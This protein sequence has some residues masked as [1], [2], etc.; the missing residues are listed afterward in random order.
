MKVSTTDFKNAV[1]MFEAKLIEQS[2]NVTNK[3]AL[4]MAFT[5]FAPQIDAAIAQS[6]KDGMVDVDE[7]R[8][9][10]DAGIKG[11]G[12][13]IVLK[14]QLPGWA[15][16]LGVSIKDITITAD[17]ADEFFTRTIPSVSPSAI[18]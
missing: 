1:L 15:S 13:Q 18:D 10:V 16:L 9:L 3:S 5:K 4:A 6:A 11:G 2:S 12:G 7:L 8:E 14:P 17:E